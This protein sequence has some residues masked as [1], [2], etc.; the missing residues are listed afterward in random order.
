M[1][2]CVLIL[3][4]HIHRVQRSFTPWQL[5][6]PWEPD[7]RDGVHRAPPYPPQPSPAWPAGG[8]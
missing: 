3:C 2:V 1:G 6:N 8:L 4:E 7:P 5:D